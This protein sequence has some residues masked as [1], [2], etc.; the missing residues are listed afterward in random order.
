[1]ASRFGT[2][3]KNHIIVRA[4]HP[5][6]LC[7]LGRGCINELGHALS[8]GQ[9]R[10]VVADVLQRLTR[11]TMMHFNAEEGLLAKHGYPALAAHQAQHTALIEKVKT[12][13]REYAAGDSG[14]AISLMGFL[15]KR[16]TDHIL[17]TDK[18]YS[19]FLTG[20]GVR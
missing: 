20:R 17:K 5:A 11:Y 19:E 1:M 15:Q 12:Y 4:V 7:D 14:V 9:G 2:G 3:P 10:T 6:A 8:S 18:Q 16:L 13:Q